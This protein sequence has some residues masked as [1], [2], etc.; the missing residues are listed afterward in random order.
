MQREPSRAAVQTC[1][2]EQRA[3]SVPKKQPRGDFN[4]I[5][6]R[7]TAAG[8]ACVDLWREPRDR[9]LHGS[10]EKTLC[11]QVLCTAKPHSSSASLCTAASNEKDES[12]KM[13]GRTI[14]EKTQDED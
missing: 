13:E 3:L 7:A 11:Y 8:R 5:A 4:P 9:T 6:P 14:K 10:R 1:V 12:R 2:R